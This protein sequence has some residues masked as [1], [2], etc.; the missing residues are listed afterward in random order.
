MLLLFGA[1]LAVGGFLLFQSLTGWISLVIAVL[2][3]YWLRQ[4]NKRPTFPMGRP[5]TEDG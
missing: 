5:G 1:M 3:G 2:G 4:L